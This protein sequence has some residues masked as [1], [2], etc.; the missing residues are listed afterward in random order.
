MDRPT[1]SPAPRIEPHQSGGLSR[2]RLLQAFA[3]ASGSAA[4][5]AVLAGCG[6]GTTAPTATPGSSTSP[7]ATPSGD[8]SARTGTLTATGAAPGSQAKQGGD[9]TFGQ[10]SDATT[11][12]PAQS[13]ALVDYQIYA[14]IFDTL[15]VLDAQGKVAPGLAE[16]W[17]E[18]PDHLS[19]TLH[20]RKGV[21]FHDGTDFNASAV[22][23]NVERYIDPKLN[24][25]RKGEIPT[26][27][28]VTVIDPYTARIELSQPFVVLMYS[29]ASVTGTM[30]SPAA[31]TKYG[32]DLARNPVGTGPF[33]F[34]EWI[35]GDH[36]LVTRNPSYWK[37]GLPHLN[38][39]TYKGIADT[40][41]LINGMKSGVI[42]ATYSVPAKD[43]GALKSDPNF[44]L[45]VQPS[46]AINAL[47][48]NLAS[49]PFDRKEI[50][51]ALSWTIDRAAIEK[52]LYFDTG[53]PANSFLSPRN[54]GYNDQISLY[55]TTDTGKAKQLLAA[56]GQ[57]NGFKFTAQT[58]NGPEAVQ[59]AQAVK[60]QLEAINVTMDLQLLDGVTQL[61][62]LVAKQ[63]DAQFNQFNG[64]V[65]PFQGLNRFFSS[66]S[67][68]DVYSYVSPQFDD[69]L[70]K[71]SATGDDGAR[72]AIYKQMAAL[73]SEDCP[74]AFLHFPAT[75]QL[76]R[77]EIKGYVFSPDLMLHLDPV[78]YAS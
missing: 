11:L 64:G 33:V 27:T 77:K 17:E 54:L 74:W 3:V 46:T 9:I 22:K 71:A 45:I 60:S 52:A 30:V 1:A 76:L 14:G 26:V 12:D 19:W 25:P 48:F 8:T 49:P 24:F 47:R 36:V 51:Q 73:L 7:N 23:V 29:F 58:S 67:P 42:H 72:A 38:S 66:K 10:G 61:Q 68:L 75:T 16:S 62:K 32:D 50:R 18:A 63:F 78:S 13:T 70:A 34:K 21:T 15:A 69:L 44:Q 59:L 20:L 6:G 65:E 31:I 53:T 5:T 41:V 4:L 28:G 55:K 2:R 37:P 57:P 39:V 56:G 40:T 35:K 43:V